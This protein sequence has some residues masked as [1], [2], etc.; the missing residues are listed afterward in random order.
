MGGEA[1]KKF[2]DAATDWENFVLEH[3]GETVSGENRRR[4]VLTLLLKGVGDL[5]GLAF[6]TEEDLSGWQMN[7]VVKVIVHKANVVAI[8]VVEAAE[9]GK[10]QED[11]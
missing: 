7:E 4:V 3:F 6:M 1:P 5:E 2:A 10:S 9:K 8:G 11:L